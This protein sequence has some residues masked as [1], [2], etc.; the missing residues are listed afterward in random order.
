MVTIFAA[1]SIWNMKSLYKIYI[2]AFVLLSDVMLFAQPG[3]DDGTGGLE[4]NDTPA[5]PI[6]GKLIWLAL[7][8]I[9]FAFYYFN[10][11]RQKA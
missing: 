5:A 6:N 8:G 3:D 11:K 4:G 2:L 1:Y 7:V 10:K 9:G